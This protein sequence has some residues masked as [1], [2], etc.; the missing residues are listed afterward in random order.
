MNLV[1]VIMAIA[2]GWGVRVLR[3][4]NDCDQTMTN[5]RDR[6][7][8]SGSMRRFAKGA[9]DC[10]L[11][12]RSSGIHKKGLR[13]ATGLSL[14]ARQLPPTDATCQLL[15]LPNKQEATERQHEE[16]DQK[17]MIRQMCRP[18]LWLRRRKSFSTSGGCTDWG[19]GCPESPTKVLSHMTRPDTTCH[20]SSWRQ[21]QIVRLLPELE[22]QSFRN[23]VSNSDCL[24]MPDYFSNGTY[25]VVGGGR[26]S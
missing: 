2:E 21:G 26:G 19:V 8:R 18:H 5:G 16:A 20:R 1:A 7:G 6:Q 24:W 15:P 23:C 10:R 9:G 25:D 4:A 3:G 14:V 11:L 22:K 13:F 17:T 12:P